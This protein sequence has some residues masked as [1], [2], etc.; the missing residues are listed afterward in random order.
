MFKHLL[1]PLDGSN[2]AATVLSAAVYVA[3]ITGATVTLLHVIEHN[4]P[5]AVHG[6]RH[7]TTVDEA[8]RYLATIAATLPPS[9]TVKQHVHPN[10]EDDV[11]RSIVVHARE[12]GVDLIVMCTH[13]RSN[14]RRWLSGSI[15]QKVIALGHTPVLLIRPPLTDASAYLCQRILVPLDGD[16]AHEAGLTMAIE[17]AQTCHASLHLIMVVPTPHT[18]TGDGVATARLLPATTAEALNMLRISAASYLQGQE[19]RL[20]AVGLP[21]TTEVLR[22][23]PA[24]AIAQAANTANANLI[25]MATHA[26]THLD[27][28][29]SG[30]VAPK[31]TS[32]A[33]L[34]LLLV[35][36]PSTK[37]VE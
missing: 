36:V 15:A 2:L 30:S 13:G 24:T 18:L 5:Q 33:R 23:D 29:W 16:P 22:G 31:V 4:P 37:P 20:T 11:A 28:F 9:I 12:F 8:R 32:R 1:V 35:P 17:V 7:L 10:E 34:P 19:A 21:V 6:E 14:L 26:K 3:Q 27:A 25:V